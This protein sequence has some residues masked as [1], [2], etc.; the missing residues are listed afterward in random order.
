M[1]DEE[2][3]RNLSCD[4]YEQAV[5]IGAYS[6]SFRGIGGLIKV[7]PEDF[8]VWEVLNGGLEAREVFESWKPPP[9]PPMKHA[10]VVVRKRDRETLR[11]A[12]DLA[13][14]LGIRLRAVKTFGLK[15]RRAVAWQFMAVPARSVLE[16]LERPMELRRAEARVVGEAHSVEPRELLF[17]RF[18]VLVRGAV[19]DS[20]VLDEFVSEVS[21][22]GVPNFYGL[23]RFGVSRPITHV[24]GY[25]LVR[26][27][28]EAAARA[29]VGLST[30]YEPAHLLEFRR[31]FFESGDWE[32]AARNV[33]KSLVYER[34]LL[35]HIARN[36]GDF[37]GAFRRLPLRIRRLFVESYAS[38]VFNRALTE[39]LRDGIPL[40]EPIEGDLVARIDRFGRPEQRVYQVNRWNLSEAERRVRE[41]TMA[42]L[43][44]H[45]GHSIKLPQNERG[46]AVLRVLEE[47]GLRPSSFRL[48][49][50]A[51]ASSRGGYRPVLLRPL[52]LKAEVVGEGEVLVEMALPR[53]S[54]AT[55]VLRELMKQRCALSYVGKDVHR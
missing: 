22:R 17:N 16:R 9:I 36:P 29:F 4:E 40:D 18:R 31:A 32:W 15:D 47:D 52:H 12:A 14:L 26:G 39:N 54:F 2:R 28:L 25:H 11:V 24:V 38:Y 37:V 7:F 19:A 30:P 43:L 13:E 51:E 23:Q 50:L 21:G 42:V 41:G 27:D 6:T 44:P 34:A 45:P 49:E 33:P 8:E 5:G 1:L 46:R 53:G 35:S 48:G 55:V 10:L 20:G 3:Y